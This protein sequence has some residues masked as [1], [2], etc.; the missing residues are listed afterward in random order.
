MRLKA[1]LLA[2]FLLSSIVRA[3]PPPTVVFMTDFGVQ[4]DSVAICKGVMLGIEPGLRIIDLSHQVTPYSILDGARFLEGAS[5]YYPAG[6]V[7]VGVIDPGVGSERKGLVVKTKRGQF[8][9]VPDNG[10][11]TLVLERDGLEGARQIA[12]E[13]WTLGGKRSA[14]FHGRDVF[15][16]VAAHLAHGQDWREVGPELA[17]I[18][19]LEVH[20]SKLEAEGLRGEVISVEA[21]Y[22]NLITNLRAEDFETLGYTYGESVAVRLGERTLPVPYVHTF[23]D[24]PE[25]L[26]L[27]YVDSRGRMGLALNLGD[28][29]TRQGIHPPLSILIPRKK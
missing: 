22:G 19:K 5:P 10:L 24:V 21:P 15:S 7:F 13:A 14:T 20:R 4:D 6:T 25:G 18:V 28:F 9:V 23:S 8:F 3:E 12:N 16:P 11:A 26:P 2:C 17:S 27:L 29:A 1:W